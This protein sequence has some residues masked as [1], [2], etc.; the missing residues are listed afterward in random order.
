MQDAVRA[1][2]AYTCSRCSRVG[3]GVKVAYAEVFA[4]PEH[5]PPQLQSP[6]RA[7]KVAGAIS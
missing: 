4:N 2:F 7:A 1:T 3:C 5:R 6:D